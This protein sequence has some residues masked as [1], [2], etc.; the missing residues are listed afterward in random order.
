MKRL[1]V[2]GTAHLTFSKTADIKSLQVLVF[3]AVD[4][5]LHITNGQTM[6]L[7]VDACRWSLLH[8]YYNNEI[9][10]QWGCCYLNV[11]RCF[12]HLLSNKSSL[13]QREGNRLST[14]TVFGD[15]GSGLHSGQVVYYYHSDT[16][17]PAAP[18]TEWHLLIKYVVLLQDVLP[19]P[20]FPGTNNYI[21]I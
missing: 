7:F 14:Y 5:Y 20:L 11:T 15:F 16:P 19:F 10:G 8:Y 18:P 3:P 9:R 1:H 4:S 2:T 13:I 6:V 21:G 17:L 12:L